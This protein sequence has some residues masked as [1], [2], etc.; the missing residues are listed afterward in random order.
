MKLREKTL[1]IIGVTLLGLIVVLYF[2]SQA[3]L[4]ESFVNLE[5]QN[6]KKNV[7]RVVMSLS[8]ELVD[9]DTITYDWAAWDDTYAFI[10]DANDE[11]IESNLVDETFTG[12][13]LNFMLF[14]HSSGRVVYGKGIDLQSEEEIPIP[15][16]LQTRLSAEDLLLQHPDT[17]SSL[18]GVIL[19]PEGP[20][21]IAS[22]PI[23]TSLDEGPI[24]GTLIMGRYLDDSEIEL[25]AEITQLSLTVHRFDDSQMPPDFQAVR[26]SLSED[27]KIL[28]RP[29]NEESIAGYA[30]LKD[31]Y[32]R[33]ILILRADMPRDIFNQG[34]KSV[35]FFIL[36]LLAI[37]IVFVV[38]SVWFLEKFVL[39]RVARLSSDVI[40]IG[41][42][43][44]L[45]KRVSSTGGDELSGL[46]DAT[47]AMLEELEESN[48]LKDLFTDIMHHDLQNTVSVVKGMSELLMADKNF[49]ESSTEIE[50]IRDSAEKMKQLIDSAALLS[51]LA[52]QKELEF[53]EHD[54]NTI[55]KGVVE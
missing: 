28:I 46:A 17:E 37:G 20:M 50:S 52:G 53:E 35:R 10:E 38:I 30:L 34:Q 55:F 3:I 54:I 7:E 6:T 48:R 42:T 49:Q 24:R 15:E 2:T 14:V 8:S 25:L 13:G 1:L 39:S 12:L 32:D 36:A 31:I 9:M 18:N 44:D 33:P 22:R 45:S 23:L 43:G 47:N 41:A 19:L 26:S 11:Y 40:R 29:L 27:P 16:S 51:K 4:M 5:E 21:L